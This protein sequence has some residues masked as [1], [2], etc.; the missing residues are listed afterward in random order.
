MNAA[1]A[2]DIRDASL[3]KLGVAR[4]APALMVL[5][6]VWAAI[7]GLILA[8]VV[9]VVVWF[10]SGAALAL[11]AL[12]DRLLLRGSP[13]PD[14]QR[15]LP[16]ALAIGVE[17]ETRLD[18]GPVSR[19]QKVWVHDLHPGGWEAQ[20]LPRRVALRPGTVSSL[21]YAL[22]P[23][24]RGSFDFEGVQL[25]MSSP[26]RLW[27]QSRVAGQRHTVRVFPNFVPLTRLALLTA[28]QASRVVGAH[29][30]RRRG[31]G[32]DF[33]QL[34]EYR[35][36]DSL[37]QIDWKATARARKLISREYQDEK[38]QQVVL[39]LDTGHRMLARDGLLGHFDQALDAALVVAYLALRQGDAVGLHAGGSERRWVPAQRGA[40]AI[41]VLLRS[42]YDLQPRPEATDYLAV[43]T[44]LST[45][46]RRRALVLWITNVRDE[47]SE[48]LLGA[49]RMLQRRHVVVIASL[50]EQALDDVMSSEAEEL[51]DAVRAGAAARYLSERAK[52]HDALRRHG[53]TVLDVTSAQLPGALVQQ[54]LSIKRDGL[55]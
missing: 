28:D 47:D 32:T 12:A 33:Q 23:T 38:N 3:P 44:E 43:A 31:E 17:R 53:V 34:R 50:R 39:A 48:D 22:R 4:P 13:T 7:G 49:I 16:D 40:A 36:G 26:L 21:N 29:L 1:D 15:V 35:V 20:G 51:A 6:V 45:L 19:R 25:L 18:L 24:A 11:L 54:Y 30:K 5:L 52:A 42:S 37:R 46:Q 14:A 27:R 10:W 8:G 41:D 9:P 2:A 55:L